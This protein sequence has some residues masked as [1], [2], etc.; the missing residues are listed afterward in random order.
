MW[1]FLL[2]FFATGLASGPQVLSAK[3]VPKSYVVEGYEYEY[4]TFEVDWDQELYFVDNWPCPCLM[5]NETFKS[6]LTLEGHDYNFTTLKKDSHVRQQTTSRAMFKFEIK[7]SDFPSGPPALRIFMDVSIGSVLTTV[8]TEKVPTESNYHWFKSHGSLP[9]M[10]ICPTFEGY[11]FGWYYISVSSG[12][13]S[14]FTISWTTVDTTLCTGPPPPDSGNTVDQILENN[15]PHV[16]KNIK[17]SFWFSVNQLCTNFSIS[18]QSTIMH[19]SLGVPVV[20]TADAQMNSQNF[21]PNSISLMNVCSP[22]GSVPWNISLFSLATRNTYT[23]TNDTGFMLR[24]LTSLSA[25]QYFNTFIGNHVSLTCENESFYCKATSYK[26]NMEPFDPKFSCGRFGML[27]PLQESEP[28]SMPLYETFTFSPFRNVAWNQYKAEDNIP[29]RMNFYLLRQVTSSNFSRIFSRSAPENCTIHLSPSFVNEWGEITSTEISGFKLKEPPCNHAELQE[30]RKE[31]LKVLS[32]QKQSKSFDE[33]VFSQ[34]KMSVLLNKDVVLGCK[35]LL[36]DLMDIREVD[37]VYE[38]QTSCSNNEFNPSYTSDPCCLTS[39][40]V[41]MCCNHNVSSPVTH[42]ESVTLSAVVGSCQAARCANISFENYKAAISNSYDKD[43]GCDAS[44][45]ASIQ[46]LVDQ[47]QLI[48]RCATKLWGKMEMPGTPCDQDSACLF[49][50]RCGVYG[51]CVYTHEHLL[52]CMESYGNPVWNK[53]IGQRLLVSWGVKSPITFQIFADEA[54][55]RYVKPMCTG[56]GSI[57]YRP[58]FEYALPSDSCTDMCVR[59]GKLPKCLSTDPEGCQASAICLFN[60]NFLCR[61]REFV[62]VNETYNNECVEEKSCNWIIRSEVELSEDECLSDMTPMCF[63]CYSPPCRKLSGWTE[64]QCKQGMCGQSNPTFT[65]AALCTS[66]TRKCSI[67]CVNCNRTEC[68]ALQKCDTDKLLKPMATALSNQKGVCFFP[69][70]IVNGVESCG[71]FTRY[72]FG[73]L[74]V[75]IRSIV[76]CRS[77]GYTWINQSLTVEECDLFAGCFDGEI[78]TSKTPEEC[79]CAGKTW[80]TYFNVKNG[81][82]SENKLRELVWTTPSWE[83]KRKVEPVFDFIQYYEDTMSFITEYSSLKYVRASLCRDVPLLDVLSTASCDCNPTHKD[84]EENGEYEK[85][86]YEVTEGTIV[87]FIWGCPFIEESRHASNFKLD[88]YPNSFSPDYPCKA[89]TISVFSYN[90]YTF[91]AVDARLSSH[92]FTEIPKNIYTTLYFQELIMEGQIVTNG[93]VIDWLVEGMIDDPMRLCI[94]IEHNIEL[95][96]LFEFFEMGRVARDDGVYV[97]RDDSFLQTSF[98]EDG[99]ICAYITEPGEYIGVFVRDAKPLFNSVLAQSVIASI[100]YFLLLAMTICQMLV[101]MQHD[102]RKKQKIVFATFTFVFLLIRAVY[103]AVYPSGAI[104]AEPIASYFVFEFPTFLF[105]VMNSTVIYLWLEISEAIEKVNTSSAFRSPIFGWALWNVLVLLCFIVF[106]IVYYVAPSEGN[107]LPCS[108]FFAKQPSQAKLDVSFA[109]VVFV[110]VLSIAMAII[111]IFTGI[112]LLAPLLSHLNFTQQWN[113][114]QKRLLIHTW[115]VMSIFVIC[116]V[117]KS[118][119]LIVAITRG[120]SVP[121]IVFALL[122][123]IPTAVLLWY[124]KP[125]RKSTS[126]LSTLT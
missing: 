41:E 62:F 121:I 96:D 1:L 61:K 106:I 120:F 56:T 19:V 26:G 112:K 44:W 4:T 39:P 111:F 66:Q 126:T 115:L 76:G 5:G 53:M 81:T 125:I 49:G 93:V 38:N 35:S 99:Q 116:F 3:Y 59:N 78:V 92:V 68:E 32:E 109:Y 21:G 46:G 80:R 14:E 67:P 77:A 70:N 94:P 51:I 16:I 123:Q 48:L 97:Y 60:T 17:K 15:K 119:L 54:A 114:S 6:L 103:F 2:G 30:V 101:I 118:V 108:L 27:A 65:D 91:R 18:S 69:P 8:A 124:I 100:I 33:L 31:Y 20:T 28:W 42:V 105:L 79:A 37:R 47:A 7:E 73:C 40:Q 58:H 13:L 71:S 52:L 117:T 34:L 89:I 82:Y 43:T 24:P 74:A 64:D 122:E 36:S 84:G 83:P 57:D 23:A 25:N 63:D 110:A 113:D 90:I 86:C 45:A 10:G 12:E 98:V 9:T 22:S 55:K 85:G 72:E 104:E 107:S 88:I 75:S 50:G 11:G 29:K 87:D 95:S 102:A